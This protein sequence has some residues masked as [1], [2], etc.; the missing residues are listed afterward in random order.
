MSFPR[1][2]IL[3]N[4]N[5]GAQFLVLATPDNSALLLNSGKS[6][7]CYGLQEWESANGMRPDH[8]KVTYVAQD[9]VESGE[10]IPRDGCSP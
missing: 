10:L 7:P 1:N 9:V 5:S 8:P 2:S 4:K 6:V 3:V